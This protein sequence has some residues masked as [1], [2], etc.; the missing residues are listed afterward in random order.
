MPLRMARYA[1][2]GLLSAAPL[3]AQTMMTARDL[4]ALPQPAPDTTIWY[5]ADSLQFG[6]LF[7]ARGSGRAPV[8]VLIHGGCWLAAFDRRHI[9]SLAGAIA[10]EGIAVWSLEYRRVGNPGGGWPGSFDDIG[11]GTDYVRQ[12]APAFGLDTGR[13]IVAGHSAGGHFALWTGVRAKQSSG[14]L[15]PTAI[16]ALA[17][18]PDL[19]WARPDGTQIC[20]DAIPR[21]MGGTAAEF[22]D[23]YRDASPGRRLPLGITQAILTG[24][25][26]QIVPPELSRTYA[27]AA[28]AGGDQVRLIEVPAAGHFE[29]VAPN[30]A[31][32]R[33]VLA[34]LRAMARSP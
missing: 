28:R 30:T 13:V 25:N 5:G 8:V 32:G 18:V 6:E 17:A 15:R 22:P 20:G 4:V 27:A 19:A 7:R 2:L 12:L 34:I 9:R 16:L 3:S 23:R 31:A 10:A 21:L 14:A 24:A 11:A 33:E 29:V 26:D 1:L